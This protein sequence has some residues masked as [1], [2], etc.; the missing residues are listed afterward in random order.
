LAGLAIVALGTVPALAHAAAP[1][2]DLGAFTVSV[3]FGLAAVRRLRLARNSGVPL[4]ASLA[5]PV[6]VLAAVGALAVPLALLAGVDRGDA[7]LC[8]LVWGL[9]LVRGTSA[10][11]LIG[12]VL[13]SEREPLLG[14]LAAFLVIL[15]VAATGAYLL[16]RDG[17]PG[18]FGSIQALWWGIVTITTTGYGDAVPATALGR[19]LS[20]ILMVTGIGMFALWA[21][22]LA[23]GFGQE[24]RRREFVRTWE[25]VAQ[26]PLFRSLG[27]GLITE[28]SRLLRAR[29]YPAGRA[30]MRRGEAGDAMFFIAEGELEVELA[31]RRV[32]LQA[33]GF[34][35]ELA[36]ISG[37]PRMA[38]V[39][40]TQASTLLVLEVA[41]FRELA[42]SRPE[43][44]HALEQE[45]ARRR[46]E[47]TPGPKD[48]QTPI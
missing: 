34:V 9:S 10:F 12:R 24:I 8:G 40:A 21:G 29:R 37:A 32:R 31:D 39:L 15:F 22:I 35:G 11:R 25:L 48:G 4:G 7:R 6:V 36:L 44:M 3:L 2:F 23:N 27:A 28:I 19:L 42:A 20:G 41:E 26:V 1:V 14:V 46:G 5:S 38:T 33:G 43:L 45:G 13:Q 18:V 17:Q 16:E 30:V 47:P